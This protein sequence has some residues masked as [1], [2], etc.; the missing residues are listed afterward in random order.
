VPL[1]LVGYDLGAGDLKVA[2]RVLAADGREA[3]TGGVR[4][5]QREPAAGGQPDRLLAA[6]RPPALPPGEYTLSVTL[7][8]AAGAAS[9]TSA[10]FVVKAGH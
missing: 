6:F 2:A 1:A 4:V 10:P 9:A 7:T 5:L 3:G 8:G